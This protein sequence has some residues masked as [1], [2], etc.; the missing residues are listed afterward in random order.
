MDQ[1]RKLGRGLYKVYSGI[2]IAAMAFV[3]LSVIFTVIMRYFFGITFTFL[4]ELITLVFAF[5]TFW[6]VGMCALENEHVVIDFFYVKIPAK[7]RRW[8]DV[9]NYLMVMAATVI[10]SY[11]SIGWI[12]VAG[13][14]ISNGMRI[15]YLYIYGVMP[16]GLIVSLVAITYKLVCLI[17]NKPVFA[18]TKEEEETAK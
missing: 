10:I 8:V 3:A 4:E 13:K 12:E 1:I 6:S 9:F 2:G 16:L 17:L 5:A 18:E 14:T 15:R 7:I 11:Y